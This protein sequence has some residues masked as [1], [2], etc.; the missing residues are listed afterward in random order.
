MQNG[1]RVA[2]HHRVLKE[3]AK[4]HR[5]SS[6]TWRPCRHRQLGYD[7]S[8]PYHFNSPGDPLR[9]LSIDQAR[10]R[11]Q[12]EQQ[13]ERRQCESLDFATPV[14]SDTLRS[15]ADD[16]LHG[17]KRKNQRL[18]HLLSRQGISPSKKMSRS[19]EIDDI[20]TKQTSSLVLNRR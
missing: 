10:K 3:P 8:P 4:A 13:E 15:S 17:A 6:R 16:V 1:G 2:A 12:H 18:L 5:P 14:D 9:T 11:V 7:L 19:P 20:G